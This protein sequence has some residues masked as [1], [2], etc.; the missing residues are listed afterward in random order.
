MYSLK[1]AARLASD[2][3]VKILS[4]HVYLPCQESPELWK[5]QTWYTVLTL[6][7]DNFGIKANSMEYARHLIN[8]IRKYFK[9]SIDWEG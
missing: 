6:C 8:A 1:Q 2:N 5:N 7:V 9:C 4:P 3:L